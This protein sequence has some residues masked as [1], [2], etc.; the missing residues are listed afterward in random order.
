M[1]F[2]IFHDNFFDLETDKVSHGEVLLQKHEK[3]I[4]IWYKL[5]F[6]NFV[7]INLEIGVR[8]GILKI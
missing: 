1:L 6:G 8:I 5:E 4:D 2:A 3:D 7:T